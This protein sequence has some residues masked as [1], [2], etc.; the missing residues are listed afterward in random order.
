[1][2]ITFQ[3]GIVVVEIVESMLWKNEKRKRFKFNPCR[4]IS[5]EAAALVS[6]VLY[7]DDIYYVHIITLGKF[8]SFRLLLKAFHLNVPG[9]LFCLSYSVT[10]LDVYS[11]TEHRAHIKSSVCY[12]CFF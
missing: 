5:V 8:N 9:V 10:F 1:M 3:N 11:N 6:H 7:A 2:N 4:D 12:F